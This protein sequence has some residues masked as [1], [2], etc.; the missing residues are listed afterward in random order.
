[1][2]WHPLSIARETKETD[3]AIRQPYRKC[4]SL[5]VYGSLTTIGDHSG[6][7]VDEPETIWGSR[8]AKTEDYEED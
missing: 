7:Q 4:K 1:M 8:I 2:S 3:K 6:Y 5:T